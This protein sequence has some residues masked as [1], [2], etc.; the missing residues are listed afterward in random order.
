MCENLNELVKSQNSPLEPDDPGNES[1]QTGVDAGETA[2]SGGLADTKPSRGPMEVDDPVYIEAESFLDDLEDPDTTFNKSTLS[3]G[4][5]LLDSLEIRAGE[6]LGK[7]DPF[8]IQQAK[9]AFALLQGARKLKIRGK[10]L[11]E[12]YIKCMSKSKFYNLVL[13]GKRPEIHPYAYLGMER[14]LALLKLAKRTGTSIGD[15]LRNHNLIFDP[16]GEESLAAFKLRVDQAIAA[17]RAS[18]REEGSVQ[19]DVEKFHRS[20]AKIEAAIDRIIEG[21]GLVRQVDPDRV[22]TLKTKILELEAS[23]SA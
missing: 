18:R 19:Q 22:A 13:I 5:S 12:T 20:A 23:L 9:I 4:V 7:A 14:L 16:D 6:L 2:E 1:P 21:N 8:M 15:L 11:F 3:A 10:S 17:V